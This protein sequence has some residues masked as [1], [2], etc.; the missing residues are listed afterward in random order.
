M[1]PFDLP[2][3]DQYS[4]SSD[5]CHHH[6][7]MTRS[8]QSDGS[9]SWKRS[10]EIWDSIQITDCNPSVGQDHMTT[11]T[12]YM[13]LLLLLLLVVKC[14]VAVVNI[15]IYLPLS[16]VYS[17]SQLEMELYLLNF[18]LSLCRVLWKS[19]ATPWSNGSWS[20]WGRLSIR[21]LLSVT[22]SDHYFHNQDLGIWKLFRVYE[23]TSKSAHYCLSYSQLLSQSTKYRKHS[24]P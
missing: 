21:G 11:C 17:D 15:R 16:Q 7:A 23:T 13:I 3:Q 14:M 20:W 19:S 4:L 22:Q 12:A 5:H 9:S 2:D 6:L 24:V 8:L 1:I 18:V 10:L